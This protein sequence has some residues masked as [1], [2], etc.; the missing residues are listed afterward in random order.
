MVQLLTTT[1]RGHWQVEPFKCRK[2]RGMFTELTQ[3]KMNTLDTTYKIYK[4]CL[5]I[6]YLMEAVSLG[7][8]M[9]WATTSVRVNTEEFQILARLLTRMTFL[10]NLLLRQQAVE[11]N[12]YL[13]D[14]ELQILNSVR[15]LHLNVIQ[16]ICRQQLR[17]LQITDCSW[18][19]VPLTSTTTAQ[20]QESLINLQLEV[21]LLIQMR[22]KTQT[23]LETDRTRI[24]LYSFKKITRA[25]EVV[26]QLSYQLNSSCQCQISWTTK[27]STFQVKRGKK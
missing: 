8:M 26:L 4:D 13:L 1:V 3:L 15:T 22:E 10:N 19:R 27:T 18:V 20:N 12:K 21:V 6:C 14:K 7:M 2:T 23:L 25:L 9:R 17:R 16:L 5:K 24:G 11:D